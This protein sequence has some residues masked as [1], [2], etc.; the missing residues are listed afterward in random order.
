MQYMNK[1]KKKAK[2]YK[3]SKLKNLIND[4]KNSAYSGVYSELAYVSSIV[5]ILIDNMFPKKI[6]GKLVLVVVALVSATLFHYEVKKNKWSTNNRLLIFFTQWATEL[7]YLNM[8]VTVFSIVAS[9]MGKNY[10]VVVTCGIIV[11]TIATAKKT[12]DA[13]PE[14]SNRK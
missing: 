2:Q 4:A 10:V 7:G 11:A 3:R 14:I 6:I 8:P 13:I 9:L 12:W 5:C 1:N